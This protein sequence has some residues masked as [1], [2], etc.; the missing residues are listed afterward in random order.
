MGRIGT[1]PASHHINIGSQGSASPGVQ[2]PVREADHSFPPVR[3]NGMH[4]DN[5]YEG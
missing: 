3:L 2:G 1:Q 4:K 5:N